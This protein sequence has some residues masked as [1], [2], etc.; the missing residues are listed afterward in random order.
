MFH[1][2]SQAD[3]LQKLLAPLGKKV[4]RFYGGQ[5][6]GSHLDKETGASLEHA[7]QALALCT[8]SLNIA[9]PRFV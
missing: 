6:S 9:R 4:G 7:L 1:T 5:K 8:R 2:V 3:G